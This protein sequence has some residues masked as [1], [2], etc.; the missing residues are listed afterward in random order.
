MAFLVAL[1]LPIIASAVAVWITSAIF[2]MV[3]GHHNKDYGHLADEAGFI[4]EMKK[5]GI[6]PGNY[7]FPN[8]ADHSRMKDPAIQELMKN[9]PVGFITFLRTP[10]SMGGNMIKSV[11]VYLAISTVIGYL[12]WATLPHAGLEFKHGF[13]VLGTAG[14]LGYAFS[15]LP[16]GIWFGQSNR[17]MILCVVDGIV[18]GLLT[19][20]VFC[21]LWPK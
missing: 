17:T 16:H 12:G 1:W 8:C 13:Q 2:W 20:A 21:L 5:R 18:Y 14:V 9:G 6:G 3:V 15:H 11:L 19:G 4:A 7:A 10:M